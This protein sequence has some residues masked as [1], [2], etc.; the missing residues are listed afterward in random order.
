MLAQGRGRWAVSQKLIIMRQHLHLLLTQGKIGEGQVGSFPETYNYA[1]TLKLTSHLGQNV[2]LGEGQV[3]SSPETYN[4]LAEQ[5]L[6]SR[7]FQWTEPK[8]EAGVKRETSASGASRPLRACPHPFIKRRIQ[9]I[10]CRL[11]PSCLQRLFQNETYFEVFHDFNIFPRALLD[12]KIRIYEIMRLNDDKGLFRSANI[13]QKQQMLSVEL[14]S[15]YVF[16]QQF[17][18]KRVKCAADCLAIFLFTT[19]TTQPRHQVFSVNGALTCNC[20]VLLTSSVD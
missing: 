12:A 16:R 2:G 17:V 6:F 7:V 3:G 15:C 13:L 18:V 5:K 11:F 19:K 9:R 1:S 8:R 20:A 10:F 14:S 4:E